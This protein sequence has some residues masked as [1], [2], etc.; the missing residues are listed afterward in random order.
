MSPSLLSFISWFVNKV[1]WIV[2]IGWQHSLRKVCHW[3][4]ATRCMN[5]TNVSEHC[6]PNNNIVVSRCLTLQVLPCHRTKTL[7]DW[8]NIF[9]YCSQ[10][11]IP[12]FLIHRLWQPYRSLRKMYSLNLKDSLSPRLW[13]QTDSLSW[14]GSNSHHN[15]LPSFM[16]AFVKL[17]PLTLAS[18]PPDGRQA[19]CTYCPNQ[20]RVPINLKH[21]DQSVYSTQLTRSCPASTAASCNLTRILH[22]RP[23]LC[24]R[25]WPTEEPEIVCWQSHITAAQWES[26]AEFMAKSKPNTVCGAACR[27]R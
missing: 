4:F 3:S 2:S 6:V 25:T 22:S 27:F 7:I 17:G 8:S 9:R 20:M 16:H 24:T 5:G 15:S 21:L 14:F 26:Y 12:P 10:M 18:H 1:A 11:C 19:G 13:P 23:C